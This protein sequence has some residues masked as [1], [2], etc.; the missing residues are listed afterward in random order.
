MGNAWANAASR[1]TWR[2]LA[3]T[4]LVLVVALTR[5]FATFQEQR[6]KVPDLP[7][8]A[9]EGVTRIAV[10]PAALPGVSSSLALILR[11]SP[12]RE[13]PVTVVVT[14]DQRQVC[15]LRLNAARSRRF[16]CTIPPLDAALEH[17]LEL[18]SAGGALWSIES[19][20]FA[21]HFGE[22]SAPLV[23]YVAPREA[24]LDRPSRWLAALA[25]LLTFVAGRMPVPERR[26]IGRRVMAAIAW[27]GISLLT[28]IAVAP[29]VSPFAVVISQ[30]TL[31]RALALIHISALLTLGR[32]LFVA[33]AQRAWPGSIASAV[34]VGAVVLLGFW[35]VPRW[36]LSRMYENNYSGFLHIEADFFDKNP[37]VAGSPGLRETL[38][39][40]E[41]GY[42]GELMYFLAFDP[43]AT[44]FAD[45]PAT[46]VDVVG[47]TPG[48]RMGR[49]GFS[50]LTSLVTGGDW[51]QFPRAMVWLVIA[52][53]GLCAVALSLLA[54]RAGKRAAYGFLVLLIPGFWVSI[55][56]GLPEPIAAAALLWGILLLELGLPLLG[57]LCLGGSLLVRETG[58]LAVLW[59]AFHCW[60]TRGRSRGLTVA[61][62][63]LVPMTVWRL[64]LGW[65]LWP[66]FGMAS[67]L[68]KS[69]SDIPGR[70]IVQMWQTVLAGDY[71]PHVWRLG[72][73][74]RSFSLLL[75]M[76]ALG[77][78]FWFRRGALAL[79][80]V[81]I[82]YALSALMLDFPAVWAHVWNAER[83]TFE[84]FVLTAVVFATTALSGVRRGAAIALAI[85]SGIY[86]VFF[87]LDSWLFRLAIVDL[88][89]AS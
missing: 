12:A 89:I 59:V 73:S 80:T 4:A 87:A 6:Y 70:G 60:R 55:Q 49:I 27:L 69:P 20:E 28:L 77:S 17:R 44:A 16:D 9:A 30:G 25:A 78:L 35:A 48:Y 50:M 11:A 79:G 26:G 86:L 67:I 74:A 82:V 81:T 31:F 8:A 47:A 23:A 88:L 62:A 43:L 76:A 36:Q 72:F 40:G 41:D 38:R 3:L 46:Y 10:P 71:W 45:R 32:S 83:T 54:Q 57:G 53:T 21:T 22:T 5:T 65:R 14:L 68:A 33:P 58:V 42:D 15:E 84:L 85:A 52:A 13:A 39:M 2:A 29:L 51:R 56:T 18:R 1:A 61:V 37:L 24:N 63:G 64:Y 19:L 7:V 66:A 34:A 75:L